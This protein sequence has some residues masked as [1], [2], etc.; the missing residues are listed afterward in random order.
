MSF[1][2]VNVD[3]LIFCFNTIN[4]FKKLFL[5]LDRFQ[6]AIFNSNT[7]EKITARNSGIMKRAKICPHHEIN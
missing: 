1:I 6:M 3:F 7:A 2:D 5:T 4:I